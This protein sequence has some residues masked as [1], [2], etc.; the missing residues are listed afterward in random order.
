ML[1]L[2]CRRLQYVAVVSLLCVVV[3][4]SSAKTVT[5]QWATWGPAPIDQELIATFEKMNP[6]IKIEYIGSTYGEHHPKM[7]V[8][9]A[10]GL[11][12]DVYVVDGYYT[13]EFVTNN[14]I[15]PLDDLIAQTRSI[16]MREYF[17]VAL[18]DVQ[19]RGKTY[20]LPYC[21]A[22][23]YY[24]YNAD[25]VAEAGLTRPDQHW[26]RDTFL[27]Y[28]RK[29][30]KSDGERTIRW[31]TGGYLSWGSVWPWVWGAGGD[32]MD[33]T[34]KQF[35]LAE[36][37][38]IE[39]LQWLADLNLVHGVVGGDFERQTRSLTVMYPA[40]F[41]SVTKLERPFE[42]DVTLP[43]GGPGGQK[44]I[45]KANAMS[46]SSTTDKLEEAWAFLQ[47]L[48]GPES[49]GHEIYVSNK[50]F[51]PQTRERRLWNI[52]QP[53]GTQP[54]SLR[55]ITLLYASEH[56]RP[57]PHLLQ[58]DEIMVNTI[59]PALTRIGSGAMPASAAIEQIRPMA[60]RLI[61]A[62]P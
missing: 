33:E 5:L 16:D 36:P 57:L 35:R 55:D 21:S 30:T 51:P 6:D 11:A 28:M 14:M 49:P 50:R 43:P 54:A 56:G 46:I 60:E 24:V 9:T 12:P 37:A 52:F 8:L 19:Y 34:S 25:H 27:E 31:G 2:L 22:P 59:G 40:G 20:G 48:L 18:L 32:V 45:W 4:G 23:Q 53:I 41:P 13:A 29:L 26:S 47:F 10:G 17:P 44:G 3:L 7:K 38:T 58:W 62:E 61:A 15:R 1:S 39:A 42:W